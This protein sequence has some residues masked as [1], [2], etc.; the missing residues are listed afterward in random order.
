[1]NPF[2]SF[3]IKKKRYSEYDVAVGMIRK[4]HKYRDTPLRPYYCG[5]CCGF[6]ITKYV[7]GKCPPVGE[8]PFRA[9]KAPTGSG[10]KKVKH[11]LFG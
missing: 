5:A 4:I 8:R 11:P 3:C 10:L 6:H 7:E 2:P 1:M 9:S